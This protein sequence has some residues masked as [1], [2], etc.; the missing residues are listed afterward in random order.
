MEARYVVSD[1]QRF[2]LSVLDA[3]L[4]AQGAAQVR[5]RQ[6]LEAAVGVVHD[7]QPDALEPVACHAA[8]ERPKDAQF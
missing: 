6:A 8:G 2:N 7:G 3:E 4:R 1:G 5:V